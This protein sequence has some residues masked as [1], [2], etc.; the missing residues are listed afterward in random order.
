METLEGQGEQ[1]W[2]KEAEELRADYDNGHYTVQNFVINIQRKYGCLS[3][4]NS[5]ATT[6]N[7]IFKAARIDFMVSGGYIIHVSD[8]RPPR[9]IP[10]EYYSPHSRGDFSSSAAQ[11]KD[12]R[13]IGALLWPISQLNL[14]PDIERQMKIMVFFDGIIQS[15]NNIRGTVTISHANSWAQLSKRIN[16]GQ[17][18]KTLTIVKLISNKIHRPNIIDRFS[19]APVFSQF[20]RHFPLRCFIA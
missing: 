3:P 11:V 14:E 2:I 7:D 10:D 1:D 5:S 13:A 17:H 8:R 20:G 12:A 19:I 16:N 9:L 4:E 15:I 6:S 18:S